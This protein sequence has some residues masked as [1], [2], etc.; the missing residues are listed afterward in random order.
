MPN[1]T[2]GAGARAGVP[3]MAHRL[4]DRRRRIVDIDIDAGRRSAISQWLSPG[5]RAWQ[6]ALSPLT[7]ARR[8]MFV[9]TLLAYE[10]AFG[11]T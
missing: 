8:R 6:H 10:S 7:P 4:A 5:A 2:F 1:R 3:P 9:D 11:D